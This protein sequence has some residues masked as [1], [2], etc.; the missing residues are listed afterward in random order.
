MATKLLAKLLREAQGSFYMCEYLARIV[1]KVRGRA[2]VEDLRS[3]CS[4]ALRLGCPAAETWI[5][6]NHPAT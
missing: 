4:D 1:A 5:N 6:G 3:L 2:D